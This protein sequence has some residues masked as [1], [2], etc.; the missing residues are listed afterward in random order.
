MEFEPISSA[1]PVQYSTNWTMKPC[2]CCTWSR[3]HSLVGRASHRYRRDHGFESHWSLLSFSELSLQPFSLLY[4]CEDIFYSIHSV[5]HIIYIIYIY[6]IWFYVL[7]SHVLIR[8]VEFHR[9]AIPCSVYKDSWWLRS[10]LV[11]QIHM[12]CGCFWKHCPNQL[13]SATMYMNHQLF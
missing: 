4:N 12:P 6:I 9:H 5:L 7:Y 3:L 11:A 2:T 13:F 1:R 8:Q 10:I